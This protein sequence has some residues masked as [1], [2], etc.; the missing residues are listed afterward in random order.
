MI[1]SKVFLSLL[2]SITLCVIFRNVDCRSVQ[3]PI[4]S[5]VIV[6]K[7]PTTQETVPE[8]EKPGWM[9]RTLMKFGEV[10]SRLGNAMGAHATKITSAIDKVCEIVKTI[11]P[12]IAA[13][14]HVGQFKF[15]AATSEAPGQL[16]EALNPV[17]L[18]LDEPDKKR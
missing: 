17:S 1:V 7:F 6:T 4:R 3:Y 12:L 9:R 13:V 15:C 16:A 11:I 14:C 18:N 10:T 8:N 5:D 2:I